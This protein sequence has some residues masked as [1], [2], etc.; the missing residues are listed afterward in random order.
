MAWVKLDDGWWCHPK[1][2]GVSL[3][4]RGLYI[5]ALCWS[6]AQSTDGEIPEE[7]VTLMSHGTN[8]DLADELVFY[9]LWH[10]VDTGYQIHDFL[11]YQMS[12]ADRK[13]MTRANAERKARSRAQTV[14]K[15]SQRD[16]KN[17]TADKRTSHT[18]T[19]TDTQTELKQSRSS[20]T[21][22]ESSSRFDEF[23]D[24]YDH[25][26]GKPAAKTAFAKAVK[27]A[28][29]DLIILKAK[30]FRDDPNREPQF[31]PWPQKWLNQEGWTNP[32]IPAKTNGKPKSG[33]LD[34]LRADSARRRGLT[35]V[36]VFQDGSRP[37]PNQ[38]LALEAASYE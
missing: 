7:V 26:F 9:T 20:S 18:H 28:A 11:K 36:G 30:E 14:T 15:K 12:A 19:H 35:S 17:V 24:A 38:P 8:A 3:E 10:K 34:A 6:S 2:L 27:K 37:I 1:T 13:A 23:W 33:A 16:N 29:P 31:T 5:M 4:A 25:K 21:S 32:P 22:L